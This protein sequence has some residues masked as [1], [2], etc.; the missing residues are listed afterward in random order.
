MARTAVTSV[1]EFGRAIARGATIR[2]VVADPTDE[3]LMDTIA[4]GWRRDSADDL[5]R[6]I[7]AT[8]REL[9]SVRAT[10]PRTAAGARPRCSPTHLGQHDRSR[11][12]HRLLVV[13]Q[14]EYRAAAEPGPIWTL[15]PED[16]RWY[17]HFRSEAERVWRDATPVD[18]TGDPPRPSSESDTR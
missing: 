3:Q 4:R 11:L 14:Y 7:N 13:Q 6:R 8:L 9:A 12:Q 18:L 15:I 16:G 1:G 10:G 2:V 17:D 5:R